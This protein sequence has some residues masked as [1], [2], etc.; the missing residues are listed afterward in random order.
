MKRILP[1]VLVLLAVTARTA[2]AANPTTTSIS[3]SSTT[4][5]SAQ[6]ILTVNGTNFISTSKVN[7]NGSAL[8][9]TFVSS[10]QLT[11]VVP[12]ALVATS[13]TAQ[14]TVVNPPGGGGTGGTS[15]AQTFTINN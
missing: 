6:F 12:A 10:T 11:A 15:N 9:T 3:P 1:L 2:L 8:T 4:A 13:G 5:G 14:V 7:W